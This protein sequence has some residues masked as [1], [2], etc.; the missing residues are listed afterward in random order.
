M[1]R[2]LKEVCCLQTKCHKIYNSMSKGTPKMF[3]GKA[4]QK[5]KKPQITA[6][7]KNKPPKTL[8]INNWGISHY[9]PVETN[10][11]S[12]HDQAGT[13]SGLGR[14]IRDPALPWVMV[15][16][17]DMAQIQC[18]SCNS[19]PTSSLGTS[20]CLRCGL[21][22]QKQTN[23]QKLMVPLW[24]SGLSMQHYLFNGSGPCGGTGSIPSPAWLWHCHGWQIWLWLG[25]DPWPGKFC[26]TW[27]WPKKNKK[28]N[29]QIS[30]YTG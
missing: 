24:Y 17:T 7:A 9:G 15:Y 26:M 11:T 23:K 19:N 25:L 3:L 5:T 21:T 10:P 16:V 28:K 18:G 2:F 13:I 20:L 12:N 14:Q 22:K 6:P 27:V 4:K 1:S 30:I 29:C 8:N